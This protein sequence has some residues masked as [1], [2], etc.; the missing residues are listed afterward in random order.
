MVG[1]RMSDEDQVHLAKG[2]KRFE[3]GRRL[4]IGGQP[5][6]DHDHLSTR[7]S[8]ARGGLAQPE[9]FGL[10]GGLGRGQGSSA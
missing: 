6:I 8:D 9:D 7:R 4:R 5:G 2:F 10:R 1:V 3:I